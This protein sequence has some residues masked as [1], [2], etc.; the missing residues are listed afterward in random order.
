MEKPDAGNLSA[1]RGLR[2]G[3]VPQEENFGKD[4]TVAGILGDALKPEGIDAIER[5]IRID[6][7]VSQ[8]EFPDRDQAV[9][10][11]SGGWRKRLAIARALITEPE[12]LLLDEPT[13]H[14]DLAGVL[15]L[16]DLLNN[17]LTPTQAFV[18][19]SHD[20]Y[21][22]ENVTRRVIELNAMYADGF[23]TAQGAYSDFLE[24]QQLYLSSQLKQQDAM[25][26]QVK[27][28]IAWLRRGA[29]ARSTKAKGRIDQAGRMIGELAELKY[30]NRQS[31]SSVSELD[32]TSSGRRTKELLAAKGVS[33]S[34]GERTLF[35]DLDVLLTPK[36]R[37]GLIGTNGS[38]KTTLLRILTGAMEPDSGQVKR[39]DGLRIV[40]FDQSRS[41]L[42]KDLTLR[43][44]LSPQGDTVS[45]RGSDMHVS[46]WAK[47]FGFRNEQLSGKVAFLS[48]GESRHVSLLLSSCS[49]LPIY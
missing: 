20:R 2:I 49:A 42:E 14:L 43:D 8:M 11:L 41:Q 9:A 1:R 37:L 21:F 16:E 32:F 19:I 28:E 12:L 44:A 17:G 35:R 5:D 15:W 47:R 31:E 38:G 48:G 27:R 25:E 3:Y 6:I 24:K 29:K 40:W 33:K 39:A 4:K 10:S 34:F 7:M 22:L 18:V 26:G 23:L 45:Y 30:R 13:N 36:Q 46:A